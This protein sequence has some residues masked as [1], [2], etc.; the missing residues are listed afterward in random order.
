M[1]VLENFHKKLSSITV[2][3]I[4]FEVPGAHKY[5][6]FKLLYIFTLELLINYL[7]IVS[8]STEFNKTTKKG[9]KWYLTGTNITVEN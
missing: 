1:A 5:H 8:A 7:N 4:H 3:L 9:I 2:D 6:L